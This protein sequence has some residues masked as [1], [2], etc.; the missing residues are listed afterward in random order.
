MKICLMSG[1]KRFCHLL[2]WRWYSHSGAV[3]DKKY[4]LLLE[5]F[6]SARNR[7]NILDTKGKIP[8]CLVRQNS[9]WSQWE[10]CLNKYWAKTMMFDPDLSESYK[11]RSNM[12]L[13]QTT[14][15]P[16]YSRGILFKRNHSS[17]KLWIIPR[18]PHVYNE[19]KNSQLCKEPLSG[20]SAK[21]QD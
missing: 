5:C 3:K 7:S 9:C 21:E 4:S 17:N 14:T 18:T 15:V 2:S 10:F 1:D 19:G 8:Q 11:S 16:Q 20:K 13:R 12:F 6:Q